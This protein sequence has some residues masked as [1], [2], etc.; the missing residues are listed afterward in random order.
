MNERGILLSTGGAKQKADLLEASQLLHKKGYKLYATAGTQHFLEE[1]GV[2]ATLWDMMPHGEHRLE[3]SLFGV[4]ADTAH[5]ARGN[6]I[7]T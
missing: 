2:P 1:N 3:D 7:D 4:F 6:H 5:F